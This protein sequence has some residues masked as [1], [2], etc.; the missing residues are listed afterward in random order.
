MINKRPQQRYGI[1]MDGLGDMARNVV[2]NMADHRC[3][4]IG[5]DKDQAKV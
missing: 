5:S 2:L 4:V 1:G 3:A